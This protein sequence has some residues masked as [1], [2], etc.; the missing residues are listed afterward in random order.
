MDAN[1][2][3]DHNIAIEQAMRALTGTPWYFVRSRG[4]ANL[5]TLTIA[6]P[7]EN[8]QGAGLQI[9]ITTA[10]NILQ[11]IGWTYIQC[12]LDRDPLSIHFE[13]PA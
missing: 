5:H 12:D 13:R 9:W 6:L 4:G 8:A 10:R 7:Y 3:M 2:P 11:P 1:P